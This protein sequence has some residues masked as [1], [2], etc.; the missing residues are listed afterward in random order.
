[1]S[2]QLFYLVLLTIF[3]IQTSECD[4]NKTDDRSLY[5][6]S[7]AI[8]S[9]S[10]SNLKQLINEKPYVSL[11]F[12][13]QN[14]CSDCIDQVNVNLQLEKEIVYWQPV[15]KL[16]TIN[17]DESQ[18]SR[19]FN[20]SKSF[21]YKLTRPNVLNVRSNQLISIDLNGLNT[22]ENIIKAT[23]SALL[24]LN[25]TNQQ[26][27]E[28]GWPK[29]NPLDDLN[30]DLVE[31]K[32]LLFVNQ[33]NS[34]EASSISLQTILD[35]SGYLEHLDI[36]RCNESVFTNQIKQHSSL[37]ALYEF[38]ANKNFNLI[39]QGLNRTEFRNLIIAKYLLSNWTPIEVN[40]K[41]KVNITRTYKNQNVFPVNSR[42]LNNALRKVI[43]S[44][45]TR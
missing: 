41:S 44:D 28:I 31:N 39:G 35:F 24:K 1:M 38:G 3:L 8:I 12:F 18:I 29:L 6:N 33:D 5:E 15:L 9:A 37:P 11:V 2:N 4:K 20:V 40:T 23:L 27:K 17:T 10:P 16:I 42:D 22:K 32:T 25:K 26:F 43:F 36:L 21:A 45:F 30:S 7:T 13:Y 14:W 19:E 34:I